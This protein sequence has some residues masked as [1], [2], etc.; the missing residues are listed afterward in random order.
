MKKTI[1]LAIILL[2]GMVPGLMAEKMNWFFVT[3]DI[4]PGEYKLSYDG[5]SA[6]ADIKTDLSLGFEGLFT[7][8]EYV[9]IA[10]SSSPIL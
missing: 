8:F 1:V 2:L 7:T 3:G 5:S 4:Q 6:S 10:L 9:S